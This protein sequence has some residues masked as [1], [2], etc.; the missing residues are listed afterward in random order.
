[1]LFLFHPSLCIHLVLVFS[2]LFQ[3]LLPLELF[4]LELNFAHLQLLLLGFIRQISYP[5]VDLS[6][7][8]L[9]QLT[10]FKSLLLG[11]SELCTRLSDDSICHS[12]RCVVLKDAHANKAV[13][14]TEVNL[15]QEERFLPFRNC[16][17]CPVVNKRPFS[18]RPVSVRTSTIIRDIPHSRRAFLI[19]LPLLEQVRL[20]DRDVFLLGVLARG[21]RLRI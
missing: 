8:K 16:K 21:T 13:S 9:G 4:H 2:C 10:S 6:F 17:R 19:A 3:P 20:I 12:A 5:L 1:M 14:V 15:D 7:Q 18:L 11:G